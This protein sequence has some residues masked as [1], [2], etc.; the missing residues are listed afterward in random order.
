MMEINNFIKALKGAEC[1]LLIFPSEVSNRLDI[2]NQDWLQFE[3][4]NRELVIRK[5]EIG[6]TVSEESVNIA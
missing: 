1:L 6:D 5:L 4:K 2:A 3:I